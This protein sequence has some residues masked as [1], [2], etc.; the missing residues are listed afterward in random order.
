[1]LENFLLAVVAS[2]VAMV[3]W[4][5]ITKLWDN[6]IAWILFWM[7]IGVVVFLVGREAYNYFVPQVD[8]DL[9][10]DDPTFSAGDDID[11]F[12]T[13]QGNATGIVEE[14]ATLRVGEAQ[15][16]VAIRGDRILDS[17]ETGVLIV[18]GAS[19]VVSVDFGEHQ[20]ELRYSVLQPS[21]N[22]V[23]DQVFEFRCER[24]FLQNLRI[25]GSNLC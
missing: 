14:A 21:S 7:T 13:N 20:C 4:V 17:G 24:E 22:R 6:R 11:L 9:V 10:V 18:D 15:C 12:A 25:E 3:L 23:V 5:V 16:E 1:M 19:R 8:V 2:L